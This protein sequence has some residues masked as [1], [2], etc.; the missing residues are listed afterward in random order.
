MSQ[1]GLRAPDVYA[2]YLNGEAERDRNEPTRTRYRIT[3]RALEHL[4]GG[5]AKSLRRL[6]GDIVVVADPDGPGRRPA[7]ITVIPFG[8]DSR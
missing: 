2:I 5:R 8:E 7:L 1:R 3:E 6:M 4:D